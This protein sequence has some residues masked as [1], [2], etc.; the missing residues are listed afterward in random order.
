MTSH[1]SPA[2]ALL[3]A[4][5]KELDARSLWFILADGMGSVEQIRRGFEKVADRAPSQASRVREAFKRHRQLLDQACRQVRAHP[6]E[7]KRLAEELSQATGELDQALLAHREAAQMA[8]GP[9]RLGG[10]NAILNARSTKTLAVCLA[11]ERER[12]EHALE[13]SELPDSVR[14][15][16]RGMLDLVGLMLLEL[17]AASLPDLLR[18]YRALAEEAQEVFA[19]AE[20]QDASSRGPT[21]HPGLNRLLHAARRGEKVDCQEVLGDV[22][23][24]R[25]QLASL[26][27]MRSGSAQVEAIGQRLEQRFNELEAALEWLEQEPAEVEQVAH[28]LQVAFAGLAQEG[29]HLAELADSE[30]KTPCAHCGQLNRSDFSVCSR[31][32]AVLPRM[33]AAR[34]SYVDLAEG[35]SPSQG[36]PMTE[37]LKRLM[38]AV[39]AF[40]SGALQKSDFLGQL[41]W[42][43]G[44]LER[45]LAL[46]PPGQPPPPDYLEALQDLEAGLS[47]LEQAEGPGVELDSGRALVLKGAGQAL[48]AGR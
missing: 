27:R 4:A 41:A 46:W 1:L 13:A 5:R 17:E 20:A 2:Q 14:H 31:C 42:F 12:L 26:A 37:N 6:A 19:L 24:L 18:Q 9:T 48:Q 39:G 7:L 44:L 21:P 36:V 34:A 32:G 35:D 45:A 3:L 11:G 10:A 33:V 25:N 29:R 43:R 47:F 23:G 40:E 38:E 16:L 30:G 22:A 15:A 8:M 28:A